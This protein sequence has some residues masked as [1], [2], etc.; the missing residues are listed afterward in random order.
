M[1]RTK[2]RLRPAVAATVVAL[3]AA[4]SAGVGTSARAATPEA[5]ARP[6]HTPAKTPTDPVPAAIKQ[7]KAT[8]QP[9]AIAS[10]T[11]EYSTT[12]ANPDGTLTR[13]T[14]TNPKRVRQGGKWVPIDTTLVRRKDG[15]Y[16]PKA[17]LSQLSVSGG[18]GTGLL[19]MKDGSRTLAFSWAAA[20]PAPV[21]HGDTA[22][23]AEVY[24]GVDLQIIADATGY[25][26]MLVVKTAQAAA[27]PALAKLDLGVRTSGLRLAET[28]DGGAQAVDS[29]TGQQI[30]QTG[31]AAMWDSSPATGERAQ[32][33][34]TTPQETRAAAERLGGHRSKLTVRLAP[35]RQTLALDQKL[36]TAK[37]TRFPVY[38]D[39]Y[40]SG[41]PSQ[42]KW[43][44]ISSNGWDVYN[45]TSKTGATSARI[46]YD[47]WPGG[48]AERARTYY[49]MNTAGIRGAQIFDA[50]LYVV[51][52]WAASCYNT[53]AVIYGTAAPSGWGS[54]TLYWGHEPGK[55][56]GVLSTASSKELNCGT[57]NVSVTPAD[58]KFDVRSFITAIAGHSKSTATFLVEA[59][60]MND[61]YGWKQLNYGGGATLSVRYSYKPVLFNG[62]GTPTTSPSVVDQG[63]NVT[64]THTPTISAKGVN[65][66]ANGYQENVR[67]QYQVFNSAGSRIKLGYSGYSLYGSSWTVPSLTDGTYTWK[68]TVQ[69][70]SGLWAGVYTATQT[71]V[72]DTVAPHAPTVRSSQFPPDMEGGAYT[73]KG[74]FQL[75]NDKT[76]NVTGYLF[77]LDHDLASVVYASTKGT[78]WTSTTTLAAQTIYYAKAD[79]G[80]G[81]G[82]VVVNGSAGVSFAPITSG[83]RTLYVKAVD[84]AGSTSPQTAYTF[85]AGRWTP[86]IAY[87]SKL[88]S[89]WTATN[90]DQTTTTVPAATK[91]GNGHIQAQAATSSVYFGDGYQA[92][93][94]GGP[95]IPGAADPTMTVSFNVPETGAWELGAN[96]TEGHTYGIFNLTFDQGKS[97][98]K[99]LLTGF[100]GYTSAETTT[101]YKSFGALTDAGGVPMTL[102]QGVHTLTWKV[103]GWNDLAD[104]SSVG[105]DLIRL[106]P[107]PTCWINDTSKCRNNAAISRLTTDG[108]SPAITKADAD[109]GGT[110]LEAADLEAA[111]WTEGATITVNGAAVKLP[112]AFGHGADDNILANGQ[113]VRVPTSGV[114]NRGNAVVFVGL[115][116]QGPVKT[117]SGSITYA[118]TSCG[119]KSQQFTIGSLSDWAYTPAAEAVLT[120]PRRNNA[121]ATRSAVPTS[122]FAVTVPLLCPGAVVDSIKLPVQTDVVQSGVPA[123]H[124]FG[125]GIRPI[126]VTGSAHWVGSWSAAQDTAVLK[127]DFS[128]SS[129]ATLSNQ[130]VRIPARLSIGTKGGTQQVRVH[131]ANSLGTAPVTFD[132]AS[133]AL[134]DSTA[135]GATAAAVPIPL[136]FGGSAS[137][138]VPAGGDVVSDAVTLTVPDRTTVL[139]SVQVHGNRATVPGHRDAPSGYYTTASDGLDHTTEQS[140]AN[141]HLSVVQGVPYLSGI[142]VTT[143]ASD[144]DGALVLFGDQTINSDRATYAGAQ[145][146]DQLTDALAEDDRSGG[147]VPFGVL[148]QGTSNTGS[149]FTLPA[150]DSNR[151]SSAGVLVDR[152]ILSQPNVRTVL[153]SAGTTDL[154]ACTDT[155]NACADGVTNR[156]EG[157]AS[158]A[159]NFK[160][161]GASDPAAELPTATGG[162]KVYVATLPPFTASHTANQEAARE[163][164][165]GR[166]LANNGLLGYADGAI[167]FAS[168]V[169]AGGD[170]VS[171]TT[172]PAYTA[173]I[174]TGTYPNDQYYARLAEEYLNASDAADWIAAP[175][176]GTNP[177]DIPVAEWKFN[178][179]TGTTA[180]DTGSGTGASNSPT[181]HNA[182]LT[183]VGWVQGRL[184]DGF[185]GTYNGTSAYASTDYKPNVAKSYSVSAWVRLT[186]K[187]ANRTVF[188]RGSSSGGGSG[189]LTI[190]YNKAQDRWQAEMPSAPGSTTTYSAMSE[191]PAQTGVW[192]HLAVVYDAEVQSLTLYVN[193]SSVSVDQIAPYNDVDGATWIGRGP[194]EWF[195]GDITETAVWAR[196][197]GSDEVDIQETAL[198][199]MDWELDFNSSLSVADDSWGNHPGT[200]VGGAT[201]TG[202]GHADG[203]PDAV[204]LNG[205]DAWVSTTPVARTDQSF[206][207]AA[208]VNLTSKSAVYTAASQ[209]GAH[210]GRF[211][212]QYRNSCD[213]WR[214]TT[215]R[216]DADEA[217][218]DYSASP[219][220]VTLNKWTHLAGVYDASAGTI[221]LYVNGVAMPSA[222]VPAG[223]KADGPFTAGRTLWDGIKTDKFAG[224]L[225]AVQV[226]QGVIS[227]NL[228]T[229]LA[230]P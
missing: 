31:T 131:L 120:L 171:D 57:S 21:V 5:G 203:D 225:D 69:N 165:N 10:L 142:D 126:A 174:G 8:R 32:P 143:P 17:A 62:T 216:S 147:I 34:A 163:L 154:L 82:T 137:T 116:T 135:G 189:P 223:W 144:P 59:K 130:T 187:S 227:Q 161:D 81:T 96:L 180:Q 117:L 195:A 9:V 85:L 78:P 123:T 122:F 12:S 128:T 145:F 103:T 132:A 182:T 208:W 23:Y 61:K 191:N 228:I 94:V 199:V 73:D 214:F 18:G 115:A 91:T 3:L 47:D 42:V 88:V 90:N 202:A 83:A 26:S 170:E 114:V 173:T 168:A 76:N 24:P 150:G 229:Q 33:P 99:T 75:G 215:T 77:S 169:S 177:G 160:S 134:Q 92:M 140:A 185:A 210:V 48:A 52:R 108:T 188:A 205:T 86:T 56:T 211:M 53:D 222:P 40:W 124:I 220:G 45:S 166:I 98:A 125:L 79:N 80:N 133:V 20:L 178:D 72:V 84:Q 2:Q 213:C 113:V 138:T 7:A 207:I 67:I 93:L 70:A 29:R 46:G 104:G 183:N 149:G 16:A 127:P 109:G 28:R 151:A 105:V 60:D 118:A 50:T 51:E 14:S 1:T 95:Q 119:M 197:L 158:Q 204:H 87:G 141:F 97:T 55:A 43:A 159:R 193:G 11:D 38:V 68:A 201:D 58:L 22:T 184:H 194:S 89:G 35:G 13:S 64:T 175:E 212:L 200:L 224:D 152:E 54:S 146:S 196:P 4:G 112:T 198:P 71:M 157:L 100:D 37:T 121:A 110:S 36:L 219:A 66:K 139:V 101:E 74:L 41:S 206:S 179:G 106:S 30:F 172:D 162:L 63:R 167:N 153:I 217:V 129:V 164:V 155:P 111:G 190:R 49:Q 6:A 15:S 65:P 192:T 176:A 102:T 136:T 186:D 218:T 148:N 27:N 156:L 25:S 39:P 107:L 44:R 226:Y 209:E 221:T 181:P 230:T 19:T